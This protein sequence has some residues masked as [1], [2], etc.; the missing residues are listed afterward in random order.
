MRSL[1]ENSTS[2]QI[3]HFFWENVLELRG[4]L[5]E[6][7]NGGY[8]DLSEN[9]PLWE[10]NIRYSVEVSQGQFSAGN[11]PPLAV[12]A[13][14]LPISN[15]P[16]TK[17]M[18]LTPQV[19]LTFNTIRGMYRPTSKKPISSEATSLAKGWI[20]D[21]HNEHPLCGRLGTR[22]EGWLSKTSIRH[23]SWYP[24][25]LLDLTSCSNKTKLIKLTITSTTPP[26]GPYCTVSH[27]WGSKPFLN[28]SQDNLEQ[29]KLDIPYKQLP[30]TF[31]HAIR[32]ALKLEVYYLWID[33]LCILQSGLG[34]EED[35]QKESAQ[36]HKIYENGYCNIAATAASDSETGL[37]FDR[38]IFQIESS[39]IR[40]KLD[41]VPRS[42]HFIDRQVLDRHLASSP[43]SSRAWVLQE[44]LFSPRILHF[45]KEQ[46]FWECSTLYACE[47]CPLGFPPNVDF[48]K[49]RSAL[50][51]LHDQWTQE[52]E[53]TH[54]A[55]NEEG[56]KEEEIRTIYA[57]TRTVETYS[58]CGLTLEDDKLVAMSGIAERYHQKLLETSQ[59]QYLAGIWSGKHLIPSL[60]WSPSPRGDASVHFRL[61]KYRAPSWSWVSM[62]GGIVYGYNKVVIMQ[63]A[64]H[65]Q[66]ATLIDSST[67]LASSNPYGQVLDGHIVIEGPILQVRAEAF[68]N[69]LVRLKRKVLLETIEPSA[70]NMLYLDELEGEDDN[71]YSLLGLIDNRGVGGL[72]LKPTDKSLYRR[73]GLFWLYTAS[74]R[75][76]MVAQER[77][78]T[79]II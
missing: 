3:C 9:D 10:S 7:P 17:K 13:L 28:L 19:G 23:Q 50:P 38:D 49:R 37:F 78:I 40:L 54:P 66:L 61:T 1:K 51:I 69:S 76:L 21:C 70:L 77:R 56:D 27:C 67:K 65:F 48:T 46:I 55:D 15:P 59:C 36:M 75:E 58:S 26:T 34:S 35:W 42:W 68:G 41:N 53:L 14:L 5:F 79:T 25:R 62:Q 31:Q 22:P 47:S 74:A 12:S 39:E 45:G 11:I 6:T 29:F 30:K 71:T 73:V 44:Y 4:T 43:L 63:E 64:L 2:C 57:W 52:L 60:M 16:V 20:E 33:S 72:V 18:I 8:M 32:V 24:S